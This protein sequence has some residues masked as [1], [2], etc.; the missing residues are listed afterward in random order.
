MI[1]YIAEKPSLGRAIA[2]A[3]P[4]PHQRG[5][6]YIKTGKDQ[7]VSW[8][9]GHLLQQA[10]PQDYNAHF[11]SWSLQHLPIVPQQWKLKPRE[12]AKA[13]LEVLRKLVE[14]ADQ[15]VHAGDP[16]REGQLLVDE[17]LHYLDVDKQK[18][19]KVKRCLISDL[20]PNAVKRSLD[21]LHSNAEF[22]ALSRS[23]L[24]RSR[25]DWLYGINMTR[26]YTLHG[27]QAG[28]RGVL[29]IG[30]VQTPVLGLVVHR[31]QE[32]EQFTSVDYFKVQA[33]LQTEK[34]ETFY[35]EWVPSDAC[36]PY[37]DS[38]R[39][40]LSKPLAENVVKR[41]SFKPATV[42]K[43]ERKKNKQSP[44]LPHSLS[45]L[46]IDCSRAFGLSAQQVL[47]ICQTLYEKHKLITYPRSDCRYVPEQHHQL[48]QDILNTI[49]NNLIKLK[50]TQYDDAY[51][52]LD[53]DRKSKAWN[54]KKIDAHHAIIPTAAKL[55]GLTAQEQLVYSL[56]CRNY[57][58]QF[59]PPYV[60][61]DTKAEIIIEKG[62]FIARAKELVQSGWKEIAS[63]R[64]ANTRQTDS[65]KIDPDNSLTSPISGGNNLPRL[66]KN[67]SLTSL[68]AKVLERKTTAPPYFTD[69]SLMSAMTGIALFVKDIELKKVLR[70]TDGLGTEATRA[71][72]IELLF[73]RQF[74][75]RKGKSIRA[76][77]AGRIFIQALPSTVTL[78]DRTARWE[79]LLTKISANQANYDDLMSPLGVELAALISQSHQANLREL[80]GLGNS[81][82]EYNCP[83]PSE[84]TQ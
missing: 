66:K 21:N 82:S 49:Q 71:G 15:L 80:K 56:V 48:A 38:N 34:G 67:Q 36:E 29:S 47:D 84:K 60:Y 50:Q 76:T 52:Q 9:I 30:R 12:S 2:S 17:L 55:S 33:E 10:E 22:Q 72:I 28:F 20:N 46:Q 14:Q 8:C 69:A 39:R 63:G 41:I 4:K 3:L 51:A 75:Q 1:L 26:A 42:S 59:L 62:L 57:L 24:A 78:P 45:S 5:Y 7:V 77:H 6:G 23:A 79:S 40:N 81:S 70:D 16:D 54:D 25:A 13:Q 35:A 83:Q 19:A 53:T 58:Y 37:L 43:L 74:L 68:Q 11:K 73:R 65:T 31:D 18:L 64:S 27:R 44:P 32:I 61:F